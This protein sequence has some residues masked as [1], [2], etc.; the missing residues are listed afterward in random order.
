MPWQTLSAKANNECHARHTQ[1]RAV[2]RVRIPTRQPHQPRHA[3]QMKLVKLYVLPGWQCGMQ[4]NVIPVP[5]HGKELPKYSTAIHG[6]L[7]QEKS[8][9]HFACTRQQRA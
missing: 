8:A 5:L 6:A 3:K 7:G 1:S 4:G 2:A 9:Q